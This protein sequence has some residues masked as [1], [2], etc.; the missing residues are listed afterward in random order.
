MSSGSTKLYKIKDCRCKD[1]KYD[2]DDSDMDLDKQLEDDCYHGCN[3][4]FVIQKCGKIKLN[5]KAPKCLLQ[6]NIYRELY[7]ALYDGI[8]RGHYYDT[9]LAKITDEVTYN[10]FLESIRAIFNTLQ[11]RILV[12]HSDGT[13]VLD[14]SYPPGDPRNSYESYIHKKVNENHN[15]RP[16]MMYARLSKN[17][18]G[19]GSKESLTVGTRQSYVAIRIGQWM[20]GG[21]TFRIGM[22]APNN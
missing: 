11:Y 20:E 21:P 5:I 13:V 17:G 4:P 18:V 8:I 22:D 12:A 10:I 6:N 14:T 19:Y 3:K 2:S 15:T 1:E 9:D 7:Y 16:S